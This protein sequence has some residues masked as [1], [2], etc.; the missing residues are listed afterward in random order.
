MFKTLPVLV[1]RENNHTIRILVELLH[2]P[3]HAQLEVESDPEEAWDLTERCST[4][5]PFVVCFRLRRI[6]W[7]LQFSSSVLMMGKKGSILLS[8]EGALM[9][10]SCWGD[11]QLF[12]TGLYTVSWL[13][14]FSVEVSEGRGQG[15]QTYFLSQPNSGVHWG[16][17][18]RGHS[19]LYLGLPDYIFW[20][21][22]FSKN[23]ILIGIGVHTKLSLFYVL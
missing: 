9:Y 5:A 23:H 14:I 18:K 2:S 6:P 13:V 3:P 16:E 20:L 22:G 15:R 1:S 8:G 17:A 11:S 19:N 21:S 4:V 10:F 12:K 7:E